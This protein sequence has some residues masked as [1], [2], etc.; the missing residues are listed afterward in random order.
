MANY[1][2]EL[3]CISRRKGN[4]AIWS[5]NYQSGER[6]RDDYHG[7]TY[8][9]RRV[10]VLHAEI[11]LPP[12][13]PKEF[14]DRQTVWREVDKAEKRSDARTARKVI[15]SLPNELTRDEQIE[16]VREYVSDNFVSLGMCADIAIHEVKNKDD[17]ERDNPH[18]HILL[19]TRPAD[20]N[21]FCPKKNREWD[22]R[23]NVTL[24]REHWA[25][26]QKDRKS[27]V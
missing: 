18:A 21:G 15:I 11:L 9:H 16:L 14:L 3:E 7:K 25:E 24:W 23:E 10:D 5:A 20:Q 19:T 17:P 13:A 22:R 27:V 4:S 26:A 12:D 6:L 8:Y 2:F 1:H